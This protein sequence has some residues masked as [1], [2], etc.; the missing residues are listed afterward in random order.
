MASEAKGLFDKFR[1]RLATKAC[2]QHPHGL[3]A[4]G[5][6]LEGGELTPLAV[7]AI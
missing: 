7:D 5:I 3:L 4:D 1:Q 6:R 2:H